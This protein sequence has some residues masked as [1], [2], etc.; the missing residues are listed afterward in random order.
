[1]QYYVYILLSQIYVVFMYMYM[2]IEFIIFFHQFLDKVPAT[3]LG[4]SGRGFDDIKAHPFF[5]DI[6][7][8]H[9]EAGV[10]EPPYK[11]DVSPSIVIASEYTHVFY[12]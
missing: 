6:N 8:T 1:M 10:V 2:Y 11:L 5:S 3:R 4:C 7:W 9:L 12:L